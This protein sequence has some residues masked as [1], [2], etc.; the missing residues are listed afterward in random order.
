MNNTPILYLIPV[1]LSDAPL[2]EVL[3]AFNIEVVKSLH[4]FIVE[5][6][7]TARRFLRKCSRDIDIDALTFTE[8][9]VHTDPAA[10]SAMLTPMERGEC[11][12]VMS[13]AG[14]P[15]VADPGALAVAEAQRRGY[16]VVPLT[17]PSSILLS[18][19]ASGFNGQGFAFHGYLPIEQSEREKRLRALEADSRRTGM[20]HIFIETPYRNDKLLETLAKVLQ[21]RTLVCVASAITDPEH[22]S[23]ITK[24]AAKWK[25]PGRSYHKIPTIFLISA[26]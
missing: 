18:L 2:S 6:T 16:R 15:G 5:N 13:E 23:I 1:N 12:G 9:N 19:M 22:E 21:P 24:P 7:R 14:C 11:M 3:P 20:T 10:V 4:H 8:L 17:G 25:S 26:K